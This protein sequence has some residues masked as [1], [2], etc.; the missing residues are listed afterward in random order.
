MNKEQWSGSFFTHLTPQGASS[1]LKF[2][3]SSLDEGG[4]AVNTWLIAD[5]QSCMAI[6]CEE[7]DRYL[8]YD[9]GEFLTDSIDNPLGCTAFKKEF[10]ERVYEEADLNI[11]EILLGSWRGFGETNGLHYQDIII[12]TPKK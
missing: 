1:A 5:T 10:I 7:A 6:K 3:R 2:I 8:E 11:V 12:A 9:L 4:I